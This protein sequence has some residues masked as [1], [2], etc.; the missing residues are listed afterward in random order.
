MSEHVMTSPGVG[1]T[2]E[3]PTHYG[4]LAPRAD[5]RGH[6]IKRRYSL[7]FQLLLAV[8]FLFFLFAAMIELL[9]PFGRSSKEKRQKGIIQRAWHGAQTCVSYAFMG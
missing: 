6:R 8:T 2:I 4:S 5:S 7:E 3:S 9:V 1:S